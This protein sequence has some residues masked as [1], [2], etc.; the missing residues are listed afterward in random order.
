MSRKYKEAVNVTLMTGKSA[1]PSAL[2]PILGQRGI[3][4]NEFKE[5][6]SKKT[7]QF[8]DNI[9]L[10]TRILIYPNRKF[11]VIIKTSPSSFFFKKLL[12]ISKG[13]SEPGAKK[14]ATIDIRFIY[15][16][17]KSSY[18][19]SSEAFLQNKCKILISAAKSM[20]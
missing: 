9:P 10:A 8:K 7:V 5:E 13:N 1:N 6:F 12:N 14:F 3:K 18:N 16:F 19:Q 15:D 17:V 4:I 2:G 20:G 11:S